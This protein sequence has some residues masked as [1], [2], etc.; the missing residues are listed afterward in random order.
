MISGY[1]TGGQPVKVVVH[2]F[3]LPYNINN[4]FFTQ[5]LMELIRK[6]IKMYGF[7]VGSLMPKYSAQFFTEMTPK[8]V[9]GEI[10][11]REHV[12]DLANGGEAIVAV[13]KGLNKAKAVV[14]VADE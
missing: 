9:S 7:V 3:L 1:N 11:H 4:P 2:L 8:V 6:S 12:Y 5:N 14:H 13:L 10:Q